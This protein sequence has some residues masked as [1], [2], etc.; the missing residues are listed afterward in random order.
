MDILPN[1]QSL[2]LQE[3]PG[4]RILSKMK[5][6]SLKSRQ[7]RLMVQ[8]MTVSHVCPGRVEE[9]AA[10][11]SGGGLVPVASGLSSVWSPLAG[12]EFTPRAKAVSASGPLL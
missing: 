3:V 1:R 12:G 8:P 9:S 5:A 7:K 2:D 10:K 6:F 4:L 11:G